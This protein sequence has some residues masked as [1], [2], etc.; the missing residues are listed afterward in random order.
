VLN[1]AADRLCDKGRKRN[2]LYQVARQAEAQGHQ[3]KAHDI[4][5]FNLG[6]EKLEKTRRQTRAELEREINTAINQVV[7]RRQPSIAITEKLDIRGKARSKKISRQVSLWTR[8]ILNDRIAFKASAE[9]FRREQVNP[10]YS[11]QTCPACGFVHEDNRRGEAFQCR[12]CGHVDDADRVAAC[13][14]KARFGD[15]AITLWTPKERVKAILLNR[16]YARLEPLSV[17]KGTVSGRTPGT[18]VGG[19]VPFAPRGQPESETPAA[20]GVG[21]EN[22][23]AKCGQA[24]HNV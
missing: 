23:G 13:N 8:R 2:K 21:R 20:I 6:R 7:K 11:S 19:I 5:Q 3:A 14:L 15:P 17:A 9:G 10:A 22:G 24:R 12:H 16:F 4:R 1:A 18:F